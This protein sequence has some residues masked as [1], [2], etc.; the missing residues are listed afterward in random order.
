MKSEHNAGEA[1]LRKA[2]G[3]FLRSFRRRIDRSAEYLGYYRRLPARHGLLVSQEEIAEAVDVSRNWYSLLESGATIRA[4]TRL[5]AR[6]AETLML[7]PEERAELFRLALP[8]VA[9]FTLPELRSTELRPAAYEVLHAF[10]SLRDLGA[11]LWAATTEA[12][13]LTL[14]REYGAE[15]FEPDAFMTNARDAPDCWSHPLSIGKRHACD[16]I[17]KY[18]EFIAAIPDLQLRERLFFEDTLN[19]GDILTP[20]AMPKDKSFAE[21]FVRA[22]DYVGW[23]DL[24][25]LGT[26]VRSRCGFIANVTV[27]HEWRRGYTEVESEH[28]SAVAQL[29]S[30]A[31][32]S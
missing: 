32:S 24:D 23:N 6:I 12:E 15:N 11:K 14:V 10:R 29:V 31:I 28:L 27:V 20:E 17:D 19:P 13:A 8:E 25:F 18:F 5:L 22:I 21:I 4:S 16:R 9:R 1:A 2:F 7:S 30:H 3:L 26:R